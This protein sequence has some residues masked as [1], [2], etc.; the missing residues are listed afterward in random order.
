M[1]KR[2]LSKAP[3][4][5]EKRETG[6]KWKIWVIA[7]VLCLVTVGLVALVLMQSSSSAQGGPARVGRPAPDFTLNTF[8]GQSIPLSS[9]KGKPVLV[10]FWSPT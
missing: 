2:K 10:S 3:S 7:A 8:D 5:K 1:A 4:S 9:L 6:N